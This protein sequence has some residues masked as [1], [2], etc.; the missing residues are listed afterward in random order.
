V[1]SSSRSGGGRRCCARVRAMWSSSGPASPTVR[2]GVDLRSWKVG[3][4]GWSVTGD[5]E[6]RR[7]SNS[8]AVDFGSKSGEGVAWTEAS[9][10]RIDLGHGTE[11]QR[12]SWRL[13]RSRAA[14]PRRR[15]G[16]APSGGEAGRCARVA[17]GARSGRGAGRVAALVKGKSRGSRARLGKGIPGGFAGDLGEPS[18]GDDDPARRARRVSETGGRVAGECGVTAAGAD[19]RAR[20][21]AG[22]TSARAVW[23]AF[24][25]ERGGRWE[26]ARKVC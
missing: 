20:G 4:C 9:E 18:R 7:R 10:L 3:Q 21:A 6:L 13:W 26:R 14:G 2:L 5:E 11:L 16:S 25:A 23:R 12:S 8:P 17:G 19:V 1:G 22:E 24:R 15:G